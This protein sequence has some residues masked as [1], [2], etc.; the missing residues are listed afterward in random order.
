MQ[1]SIIREI[2]TTRE[3]LAERFD[4]DVRKIAAY[5]KSRSAE[6]RES[7]PPVDQ[8]RSTSTVSPEDSA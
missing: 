2:E 7:R 6:R 4:H 1:D 3:R 8:E 5:L